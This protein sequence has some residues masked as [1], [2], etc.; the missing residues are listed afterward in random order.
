MSKSYQDAAIVDSKIYG[1]AFE[2]NYDNINNIKSRNVDRYLKNADQVDY[3][4]ARLVVVLSKFQTM[5]GHDLTFKEGANLSFIVGKIKGYA[6][7]A[8]YD[9]GKEIEQED[10]QKLFNLR[11][12]Q[13]YSQSYSSNDVPS[14][15]YTATSSSTTFDQSLSIYKDISFTDGW[16]NNVNGVI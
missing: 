11:I 15:D 5:L 2:I 10:V 9:V 3:E 7:N 16:K 13:S 8:P 4:S 12:D 1:D 14:I 6:P